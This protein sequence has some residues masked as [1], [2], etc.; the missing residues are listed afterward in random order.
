MIE[1]NE[2]I[3]LDINIFREWFVRTIKGDSTPIFYVQFLSR[4]TQIE[5][6]IS[7]FSIA[8]VVETLLKEPELQNIKLT[9]DWILSLVEIF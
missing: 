5:K 4:H 2:R 1:P 3:Y 8:E 6:R 9:K 7:I